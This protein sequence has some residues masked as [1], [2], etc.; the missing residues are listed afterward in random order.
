MND[1]KAVKVRVTRCY[2]IQLLDNDDNELEFDY[3]FMSRQDA[4][5]QGLLMMEMYNESID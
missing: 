5:Q 1:Q 4:K 3:S 2:L